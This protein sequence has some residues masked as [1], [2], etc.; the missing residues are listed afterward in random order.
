MA[1]RIPS[2]ALVP[3]SWATLPTVPVPDIDDVTHSFGWQ[4]SITLSAMLRSM[5][6]LMNLLKPK[7]ERH[8][9]RITYALSISWH[10]DAFLHTTVTEI[11]KGETRKWASG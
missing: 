9:E 3:N 6:T 10:R 4:L 11:Q 5:F 7:V 2:T 8:P 1:H